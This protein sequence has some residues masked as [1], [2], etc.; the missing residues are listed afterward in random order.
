MVGSIS[1]STSSTATA[2]DSAATKEIALADKTLKS[3]LHDP[4]MLQS[5]ADQSSTYVPP[6]KGKII[7]T[8]WG[9]FNTSG[10]FVITKSDVQHAVYTE[11][12]STSAGD[13][14]WA[15]INPDKKSALSAGDFALDKYINKTIT[16]DL[17]S[18]QGDVEST[19]R[20][21]ARTAARSGSLLD[22]IVG[23]GRSGSILDFFA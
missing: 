9:L 7:G 13:A 12:G 17:Q 19:R 18:L 14:L 20:A 3:L 16:S 5:L 11:G 6:S 10:S 2:S 1:S 23:S 15:Q 4:G 21:S 22:F 8:L